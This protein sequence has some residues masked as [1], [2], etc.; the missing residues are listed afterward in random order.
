MFYGGQMVIAKYR[1]FGDDD[2]EE[3]TTLEQAMRFAFVT[4]DDNTAYCYEIIDGN[5][6]YD[7]DDVCAYWD[8]K[9][10]W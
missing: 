9:N 1:R 3:F 2:T 4:C 8:S 5:N 7:R 6:I 10:W